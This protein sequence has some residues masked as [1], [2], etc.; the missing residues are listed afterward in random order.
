MATGQEWR[1]YFKKK[2]KIHLVKQLMTINIIL[3]RLDSKIIKEFQLDYL[4]VVR[5]IIEDAIKEKE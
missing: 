3:K 1:E 5:N 4:S 2:D